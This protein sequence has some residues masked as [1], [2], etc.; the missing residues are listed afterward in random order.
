MSREIK[1]NLPAE[2]SIEDIIFITIQQQTSHGHDATSTMCNYQYCFF[3]V[4]VATLPR[5]QDWSRIQKMIVTCEKWPVPA[6]NS[7]SCFSVA[8]G[9]LVTFLMGLLPILS[10]TLEGN[11]D[12]CNAS[13][14]PHFL[15]WWWIWQRSSAGDI[16]LYPS[17]DWYISLTMFRNFFGSSLWPGFQ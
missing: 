11:P 10:L 3:V 7:Y 16:L 4:V 14:V 13:I 6:R 15:H 9:L 2:S 1:L 17:S 5:S 12:L 8:V